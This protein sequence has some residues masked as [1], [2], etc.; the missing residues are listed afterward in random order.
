M[1][2]DQ[3]F[4]GPD[5]ITPLAVLKWCLTRALEPC[6]TALILRKEKGAN[7]QY[8]DFCIHPCARRSRRVRS[9]PNCACLPLGSLSLEKWPR[10]QC[11]RFLFGMTPCA[12]SVTQPKAV[13]LS[14][15]AFLVGWRTGIG[16]A[17]VVKRID[18]RPHSSHTYS[19]ICTGRPDYKRTISWRSLSPPANWRWS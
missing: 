16:P 7:E 4:S 12:E 6:Y 1:H 17:L 5:Y 8:H 15:A 2:G 11:P 19:C 18:W 10:A 3:E 14:L 13:G 9:L